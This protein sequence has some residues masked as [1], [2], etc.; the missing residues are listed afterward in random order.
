MGAAWVHPS[1]WIPKAIQSIGSAVESSAMS[2][3]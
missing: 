1:P 3:A 2:A